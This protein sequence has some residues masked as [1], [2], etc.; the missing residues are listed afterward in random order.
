MKK[1]TGNYLNVMGLDFE[2]AT[3][4]CQKPK[5]V[6]TD[7]VI[8]NNYTLVIKYEKPLSGIIKVMNIILETN[9]K[10]SNGI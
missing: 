9:L 6:G 5:I 7:N 8:S 10:S 1:K 3:E 2:Y 4:F